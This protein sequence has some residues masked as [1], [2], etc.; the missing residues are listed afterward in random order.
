MRRTRRPMKRAIESL[1]DGIGLPGEYPFTRG[2]WPNM[3]RGGCGRCGSMR[4]F[5]RATRISA[6]TTCCAGQTG[7]SVAFDLPTQM[8]RD[9]D[10]ELS[11]KGEVGRVGVSIA[12]LWTCGC[13]T[14][15]AA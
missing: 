6:I 2:V 7:L 11:S 9:P 12:S 5:Q 14:G 15:T 8:G 13:F 10:H 1:P 4:G 3:Y